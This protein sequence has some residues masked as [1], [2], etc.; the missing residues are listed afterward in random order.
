[1]GYVIGEST[2]AE[3]G[4]YS[5]WAKVRC[6]LIGGYD[7]YTTYVGP[8]SFPHNI[9]IDS[10]FHADEGYFLRVL[11]WPKTSD[12]T[13]TG[14]FP[15][16]EYLGPFV[17]FF[18]DPVTTSYFSIGAYDAS[19]NNQTNP[20]YTS[21]NNL[22]DENDVADSLVGLTVTYT[23]GT[24]TTTADAFEQTPTTSPWLGQA[25]GAS[26]IT[27]VSAIDSFTAF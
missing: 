17:G 13:D 20:N 14:G 26:T 11:E 2:G 10:G 23:S 19:Y 27:D 9:V 4:A 8:G 12:W 22:L 7:Q 16:T 24:F 6:P 25:F 21:I 18:N 1:M 3:A 5:T 15:H